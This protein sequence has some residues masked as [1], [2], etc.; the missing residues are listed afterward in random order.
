M[1]DKQNMHRQL[2]IWQTVV[3]N[4][5]RAGS[6]ARFSN[7]GSSPSRQILPQRRIPFNLGK[8]QIASNSIVRSQKKENADSDSFE[9]LGGWNG[10]NNTVAFGNT[11]ELKSILPAHRKSRHETGGIRSK[12]GKEGLPAHR[13]PGIGRRNK[14]FGC[15]PGSPC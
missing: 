9:V 3:G 12:S 13:I 15:G 11:A 14:I 4:S 6:P 8:Q 5:F 2:P 7:S 10:P 1:A